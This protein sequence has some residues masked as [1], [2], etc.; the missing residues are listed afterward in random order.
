[1]TGPE[2]SRRILIYAAVCGALGVALGSIGAHGLESVLEARG[3]DSGHIAKR[4]D[5]FDVGVRY[6]LYHAL[7]LLAIAALPLGPP[8]KRRFAA[9]LFVAGILL[10]SGSLYLLV[11][12]DI[13]KFGMVTPLGGICLI[14]AWL[15]LLRLRAEPLT[16]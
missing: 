15:M 3:Y 1:M 2:I 5:Q 16:P 8:D 11:A 12:T 10:F 6:H 14:V 7:A 9:K 13:G 4:L